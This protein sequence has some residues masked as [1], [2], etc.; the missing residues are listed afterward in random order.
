MTAPAIRQAIRALG[1][2]AGSAGVDVGCGVGLD[3]LLLAEEVGEHGKVVGVDLSSDFVRAA[4]QA[5]RRSEHPERLDFVVGDLGD[6]PMAENSFDWLWCKDTLWPRASGGGG[7]VSEPVSALRELAR[8]VR[9]GGTV[10]VVFWSGQKLLPGYP[11]LEARLDAAQT[12]WI[13]YLRNI[14]PE[15]HFLGALGWIRS[16]GLAD[17]QAS[18]FSACIYAPLDKALQQAMGCVFDMLY[19]DARP[20]LTAEEWKLTERLCRPESPDFLPATP[21]YCGS[22]HYTL[23]TG[24]V[25]P[26]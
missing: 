22:V 18:C 2:E 9:P 24:R 25:P 11:K 17:G 14:P 3:T 12:E 4:G 26:V 6:L 20:W 10:A 15:R 21:S 19:T 16:A 8:V 7:V 13:P 5:A 1:I 23:F